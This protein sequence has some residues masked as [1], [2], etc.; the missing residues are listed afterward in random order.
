MRPLILM[1]GG[2]GRKHQKTR[3]PKRIKAARSH[4]KHAL[5]TVIRLVKNPFFSRK[6]N[7]VASLFFICVFIVIRRGHDKVGHMIR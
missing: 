5:N 1:P 2:K 4:T 3:R 7:L 6:R